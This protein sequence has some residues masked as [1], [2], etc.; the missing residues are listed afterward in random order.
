MRLT[1]GIPVYNART[2][3]ESAIRSVLEQ[4]FS[5]F[6]LIISDDGSTDDSLDIIYSFQDPRIRVISDGINKGISVRLNEQINAAQGKYFARFDADDI[7][8]SSRLTKQLNYLESNPQIDLVGSEAVIIDENNNISGYRFT[9]RFNSI[10]DMFRGNILIHPSV[11]GKTEWFRANKYKVDLN[12]AEDFDLWIRG[13]TKSNYAVID[14]PLIFYRDSEKVMLETYKFRQCQLRKSLRQNKKIIGT[15]FYF[16]QVI[17]SYMK[18]GV[19]VI[20]TMLAIDRYI[21][22]LRNKSL[23]DIS[24]EYEKELKSYIDYYKAKKRQ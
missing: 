18:T 24:H 2:H 20:T 3:L 12:G 10:E 22:K 1:I 8:F 5:D 13:Y 4:S 19:Y 6:E 23:S 21:I 17:L 16:G 11:M 15:V 7:M 9:R 14:E